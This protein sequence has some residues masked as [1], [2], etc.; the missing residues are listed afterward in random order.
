[1]L[2]AD[3]AWRT[4]LRARIGAQQQRLFEVPDA[5]ESLQAF[6]QAGTLTA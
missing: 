3:P 6:L 2:R 1:L 4:E 5:V